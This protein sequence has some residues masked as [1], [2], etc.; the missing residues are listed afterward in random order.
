MQ[1]SKMHAYLIS[2]GRAAASVDTSEAII[3][4]ALDLPNGRP[5]SDCNLILTA[6]NKALT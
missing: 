6:K 2:D 4:S 5:F 1:L 3:F